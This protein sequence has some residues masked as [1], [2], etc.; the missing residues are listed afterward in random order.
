VKRI[1]LKTTL[2]LLYCIYFV[3]P[4]FLRKMVTVMLYNLLCQTS[5]STL[6]C[7]L[8]ICGSFNITH[9]KKIT[10]DNTNKSVSNQFFNRPTLTSNTIHHIIILVCGSHKR[11]FRNAWRQ[12]GYLSYLNIFSC[13]YYLV[14]IYTE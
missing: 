2:I 10:N 6:K 13:I 4:R 3:S 7:K 11:Y 14:R 5:V 12:Y 1:Y 9:K 8:I